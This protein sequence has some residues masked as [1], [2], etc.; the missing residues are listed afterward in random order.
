MHCREFHNP[1]RDPADRGPLH[2]GPVGGRVRQDAAP[3]LPRRHEE[4]GLRGH[5]GH[6]RHHKDTPPARLH[7]LRERQGASVPRPEDA[8][9]RGR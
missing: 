7:R 8:G 5:A 3:R 6:P 9:R 4:V 2:G 1:A